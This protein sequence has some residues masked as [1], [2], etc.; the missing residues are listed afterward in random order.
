M[1]LESITFRPMTAD[2]LGRVPIGHQGEP[3]EVRRRIAELGSSAMLAFDGPG[4]SA[5]SSSGSTR[6]AFIR[7]GG[8]AFV[9]R[10][11]IDARQHCAQRPAQPVCWS[12]ELGA[13][14]SSQ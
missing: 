7:L 13:P 14:N 6:R 8:T 9:V 11:H 1:T 4:T 3:D 12:G 5:G 10:F 2:D